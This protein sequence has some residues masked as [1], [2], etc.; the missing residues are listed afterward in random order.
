MPPLSSGGASAPVH[1]RLRGEHDSL[2]VC[3]MCVVGSSPPAR[4]TYKLT[5][6]RTLSPRFIPACAGNMELLFDEITPETVHPRL[7]G[8]H[9]GEMEAVLSPIGSSPPARGTCCSRRRRCRTDRFIPACA[10]NIRPRC[11]NARA[12]SVHPRLRGEHSAPLKTT[13]SPSG[14]SPPARGTFHHVVGP[15]LAGRFIPACAGNMVLQPP[16]RRTMAVHPRLRGE[17]FG[18]SARAARQTGSSPPARGTSSASSS[19]N[20]NVRFIPACAGNI[21]VPL[22]GVRGASVHPRLRGEHH[23]GKAGGGDLYGS[24]PPARGTSAEAQLFLCQKRFIPAC[25]GNIERTFAKLF[26][27]SVHPRLRGEHSISLGPSTTR[28]GSSPPARG[29]FLVVVAPG[30]R[31]RFIPACAGNII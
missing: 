3:S 18:G 17:H 28:L 8:E 2:T 24:S 19:A 20:S 1:P 14:S 22:L 13:A 30:D 26:L 29:T 9:V 25:A 27:N 11:R 10:G 31:L 4:G 7:R 12:S 5:A 23:Q 21:G 16:R 15:V 6:R